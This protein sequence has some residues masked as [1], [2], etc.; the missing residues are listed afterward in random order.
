MDMLNRLKLA[1]DCAVINGVDSRTRRL[2]A[3]AKPLR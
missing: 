3:V 1:A 2:D